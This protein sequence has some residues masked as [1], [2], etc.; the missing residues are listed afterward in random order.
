MKPNEREE[1]LARREAAA[2]TLQAKL[3]RDRADMEA[4][5]SA[6]A[7][8]SRAASAI[9]RAL[10]ADAKKRLKDIEAECARWEAKLARLKAESGEARG[11]GHTS[12]GFKFEF[13]TSA[14]RAALTEAK[15][16]QS[17]IDR[18]ALDAER[19]A[20]QAA[21]AEVQ[22]K[23]KAETKA[24]ADLRAQLGAIRAEIEDGVKVREVEVH[25]QQANL[26]ADRLK[27][28]EQRA[29][30]A[31][32]E[33]HVR[34]APARAPGEDEE[35]RQGVT[36]RVLPLTM[37]K[38]EETLVIAEL[39]HLSLHALRAVNGTI[40]AGG[41]C[42]VENKQSVE[43]LLAAVAP[44][45]RPD[46]FRVASIWPNDADWHLA[47]ETEA[48]LDR[49]GDSLLTVAAASRGGQR[50]P[51]AYAACNADDGRPVSSE[52]NGK[53]V[54]ASS[55]RD[56]LDEVAASLAGH[57]V[58]WGRASPAALARVGAIADT[59]RGFGKGSVALWDLGVERSHLLLVNANGIEGVAPCAVGM[60]TV[61]E[62]VQSALKLKFRGAGARLFCNDDYDFTEAAPKVSAIVG[63]AFK[64]AFGLLPR[65]ESVPVLTCIGL[66]GK[67]SWFLR[68]LAGLVGSSVWAAGPR[69]A[70][71]Q[72]GAQVCRR[73][74]GRLV[75]TRLGRPFRDAFGPDARQGHLA[76]GLGRGRGSSRGRGPGPGSGRKGRAIRAARAGFPGQTLPS[77]RGRR[78]APAPRPEADAADVRAGRGVARG[79]A[80]GAA[81]RRGRLCPRFAAPGAP[82][83]I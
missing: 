53:W 22:A 29:A 79:A 46:A 75:F 17:R 18:A 32:R 81:R 64:Q 3:E 8:A 30:L 6:S 65:A 45:E 28:E 11:R 66:T 41:E 40:E 77:P 42:V 80:A 27:M 1:L 57:R 52:G 59:L 37:A 82:G 26:A 69:E 58:D 21:S 39:T 56:S 51:F 47:T 48:F 72:P 43:A 25:R 19:A 9:T 68:E 76:A 33:A 15:E 35:F 67:Q 78:A 44:A 14:E 60:A 83:G 49:S 61:F 4:D 13:D 10:Q 70:G 55:S 12:P 63:P 74:G 73:R 24:L 31:D 71:S 62:A 23:L 50:D 20:F 34:G 54:L 7:A 16:R 2:A 36:R 5:I 38:A